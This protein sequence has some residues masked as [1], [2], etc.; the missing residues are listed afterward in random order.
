MSD[1]ARGQREPQR[2]FPDIIASA[3]QA[4]MME[5]KHF[6]EGNAGITVDFR[7]MPR[8]IHTKATSTGIF[9]EVKLNRGRGAAF[10]GHEG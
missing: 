1:F 6:I 7:G 5:H 9:K 8:G 2:R 10:A 3:R 4:G